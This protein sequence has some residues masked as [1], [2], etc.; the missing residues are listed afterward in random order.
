MPYRM[1][2]EEPDKDSS[3]QVYKELPPGVAEEKFSF[4]CREAWGRTAEGEFLHLH[5]CSKCEGWI[6]GHANSYPVNTLNPAQLAGRQGREYHC[7]RCGHQ[8]GFM[9]LMS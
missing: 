9:G 7:K 4:G 1:V 3:L 6:P 5:F 2:W 8:I